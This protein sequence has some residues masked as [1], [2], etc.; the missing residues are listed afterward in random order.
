LDPVIGDGQRLARFVPRRKEPA[1]PPHNFLVRPCLANSRVEP[2]QQIEVIISPD[3]AYGLLYVS[4]VVSSRPIC[5]HVLQ[6]HHVRGRRSI[7]SMNTLATGDGPAMH[8]LAALVLAVLRSLAVAVGKAFAVWTCWQ[9]A[10]PSRLC[11]G[12]RTLARVGFA[13][14]AGRNLRA[15]SALPRLSGRIVLTLMALRLFEP[16]R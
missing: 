4:T 13:R 5:E 11:R 2:N 16:R 8:V 3:G 6:N 10:L 9:R 12:A 15:T 1:P 7:R 14:S